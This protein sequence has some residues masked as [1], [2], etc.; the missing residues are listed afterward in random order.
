MLLTLVSEVLHVSNTMRRFLGSMVWAY[1]K[2][3]AVC[4]GTA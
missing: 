2:V 3:F 4:G 1:P